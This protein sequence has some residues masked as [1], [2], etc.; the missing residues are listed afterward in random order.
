MPFLVNKK[1]GQKD[2]YTNEEAIA[3]L[4][5]DTHV[6]SEGET[7]SVTDSQG[8]FRSIDTDAAEFFAIEGVQAAS[9]EQIGERREHF[10]KKDKYDT[11][12]QE[13]L[14]GFEG[15][16]R[17][18]SFGGTDAI[19]VALGASEENIR[20]RREENS[21][22]SLGTELLGAAAPA[23]LS[24]GT[25]AIASAA[26]LAPSGMLAARA[27]ALGKTIGG[28]R[29]AI[30]AGGLEGAVFGAGQG[31]S[32]VALS[33]E[34]LTA[35]AA[36]SQIGMGALYG[37]ALVGAFG[38]GGVALERAGAGVAT[39]TNKVKDKFVA[40]ASPFLSAA[41][42]EGK[43]LRSSIAAQADEVDD[44]I[45]R[46]LSKADDRVTTGFKY[47]ADDDLAK[48]AFHSL[49]K[50]KS[51]SLE[52]VLAATSGKA[53]A[54][55][56]KTAR[57][58]SSIETKI[59][60]LLTSKSG[61]V[62]F[63]RSSSLGH[64]KLGQLGKHFD[65]YQTQVGRLAD[66]SGM[67]PAS[68]PTSPVRSELIQGIE[69]VAELSK[70]ARVAR[71][72]FKTLSGKKGIN[73]IF[74]QAPDE[75]MATIA[76]LNK[77]NNA[78]IELAGLLNPKD[79]TKLLES[80]AG[81]SQLIADATRKTGNLP[82]IAEMAVAFGIEE[83]LIPDLPGPLDDLLKLYLA[84]KMV[85]KFGKSGNLASKALNTIADKLPGG[86]A[87]QVARGF[88]QDTVGKLASATGDSITRIQAGLAKSLKVGTK[89]VKRSS[90]LSTQI[91]NS[92]SFGEGGEKDQPNAHSAFK[93]R[94]EE[95]SRAASNPAL[96]AA[97]IDKR[98]AAIRATNPGVADKL[99]AHSQ[100]TL[101]FLHGKLPKDP[102]TLQNYGLSKWRPLERDV[103]KFARYVNAARDPAA[104]V[105]RFGEQRMT[106]EDAEVLQALY[107]GHFAQVQ[108]HVMDNLEAFQASTSYKH[109]IQTSVLLGIPADPIMQNV[110]RWQQTFIQDQPQAQTGRQRPIEPSPLTA[111][112]RIAQR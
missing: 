34:T 4:G 53:P 77:S 3:L 103:E 17:G 41:T 32:T 31:V 26:R 20:G 59:E 13:I 12:G 18:L 104:I 44:I 21:S 85:G 68:I 50:S 109:R 102:G 66:I 64:K 67:P 82:A 99:A 47:A 106:R 29:G 25:G 80:T 43:T 56:E 92:V 86:K 2:Y 93:V 87:V 11:L 81:Y 72:E 42:K 52:Y 60:S 101:A 111:A 10:R 23:L 75:A 51:D 84:S 96:T 40:K 95:L 76:A 30:A 107:P 78:S 48:E 46:V 100:A 57:K 22:V 24:G 39:L 9:Q 28:L 98:L 38:A 27:G 88:A 110:S 62:D 55:V 14:T 90:P 19:A 45:A 91:L 63:S 73:A 83:A 35:E 58:I 7:V 8:K 71:D 70:A 108:N 89:A 15:L 54:L 37:G 16:G 49:R 1:T 105:E 36:F 94:A 112:Q 61:V 79:A 65:D 69:G 74:D 97:K 6:G 33:D 5:Q